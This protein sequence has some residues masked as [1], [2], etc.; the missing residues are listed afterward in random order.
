LLR[1]RQKTGSIFAGTD[2]S[3]GE[4]V[5]YE[6]RKFK[7]YRGMGSLCAKSEPDGS[8]HRY[9]QDASSEAKKYVPEGSLDEVVYQLIGGLKSHLCCGVA[10][11][12]HTA[13]LMTLI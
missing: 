4:T 11:I 7:T 5:L 8:S 1:C 10:T 3:A 12:D 13:L 9:F 6:G 2:E